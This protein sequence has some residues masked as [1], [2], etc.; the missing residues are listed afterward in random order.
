M[1]SIQT[2]NAIRQMISLFYRIGL[3]HK[4]DK[5]TVKELAIKW[6]YCV[7]HIL[8]PT[9]LLVGAL[10]SDNQFDFVLLV[11]IAIATSVLSFKLWVLIW[12][13]KQILE[14]LNRISIFSVQRHNDRRCVYQ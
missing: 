12:K 11:E 4:G 1:H 9:S 14:L 6:F 10:K 3:W 8:F 13:Q 7:Y 2:H 5:A